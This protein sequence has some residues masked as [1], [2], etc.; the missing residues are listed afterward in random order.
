M[1]PLVLLEVTHVEKL[2]RAQA[3]LESALLSRAARLMLQ[4]RVFVHKRFAASL[5]LKLP[6]VVVNLHVLHQCVLARKRHVALR[7]G[8]EQVEHVQARVLGQVPRHSEGLSTDVARKRSSLSVRFHVF[9]QQP[10]R[11]QSFA[12]HVTPVRFFSRVNH[13]VFL[14]VVTEHGKGLVADV[15]VTRGGSGSVRLPL[16]VIQPGNKVQKGHCTNQLQ[17]IV[18][19]CVSVAHK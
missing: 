10:G 15:T 5:A 12:T 9:L 18:F 11:F 3:A 14:E 17:G 13:V 1:H 8:V 2:L 16:V 4:Q 6:V 7:A 19:T